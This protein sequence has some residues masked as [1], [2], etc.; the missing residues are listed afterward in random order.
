[1]K[2]FLSRISNRVSNLEE[3]NVDLKFLQNVREMEEWYREQK[4]I[5]N[6]PEQVALR[7]KR[8]ELKERGT[9]L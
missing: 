1:M 6:S 5:Y 3:R 9:E 8:S 4:R 7:K 2:A